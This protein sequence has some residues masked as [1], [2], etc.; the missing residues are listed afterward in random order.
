M[1]RP[2]SALVCLVLVVSSAWTFVNLL[3][4][5]TTVE[6]TSYA[7]LD[8]VAV[9][10]AGR[11]RLTGAPAGAPVVVTERITRDLTGPRRR[12]THSGGRLVL[13]S[14]CHMVV[15]T[16]CRIDYEIAVPPDV[17]I[18]VDARDGEVEAADLRSDRPLRLRSAAGDVRVERVVAPELDASSAAGDVRL[19]NVNAARIDATSAA[20]EVRVDALAPLTRLVARSSAGD[21]HAVVPEG[22]YAL[23][24]TA[25]AG[26]V[27]AGAIRTDPDSRRILELRSSAGDV[28]AEV[29]TRR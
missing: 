24:A 6:R 14:S 13:D 28:R 16:T 7:A 11:V 20:G 22:I 25:G 26:D 3:A 23:R 5:S 1:L 2:V 27:R 9:D 29:Q 21:V 17:R 8:E 4:R 12:V 18:V 10:D 19:L 15:G